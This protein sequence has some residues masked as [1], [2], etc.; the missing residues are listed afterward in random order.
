[1]LVELSF[2]SLSFSLL[3]SPL[4]CTRY[5]LMRLISSLLPEIKHSFLLHHSWLEH[6][7]VS[8][9]ISCKSM[10]T[11]SNSLLEFHAW[12]VLEQSLFL[13]SFKESGLLPNLITPALRFL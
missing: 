1:G 8:L 13:E 2:G 9:T 4:S 10:E 7:L 5:F 12:Y 3:S 11:A 6:F